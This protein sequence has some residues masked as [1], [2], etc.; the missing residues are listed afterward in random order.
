MQLFIIFFTKIFLRLVCRADWWLHMVKFKFEFATQIT[1]LR[2]LNLFLRVWTCLW[3]FKTNVNLRCWFVW[4]NL[5]LANILDTQ[6]WCQGLLIVWGPA[7][8]LGLA[9]C[10]VVV[11]DAIRDYLMDWVKS[12]VRRTSDFS[13]I[14]SGDESFLWFCIL[15]WFLDCN[16]IRILAANRRV[17]EML[18]LDWL[19]AR[20]WNLLFYC[21]IRL[22][23]CG[24][25]LVALLLHTV[26]WIA[27][28]FTLLFIRL[29]IRMQTLLVL[30][31]DLLHQ[32]RCSEV[33]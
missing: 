28:Y 6:F 4:G 32:N 22:T 18:L 30:Q 11:E 1:V 27:I 14:Q 29:D 19:L 21:Y 5:Y 16:I 8:S 23:A 9:T 13:D 7:F 25:Y 10:K 12:L 24:L 31:S 2:V 17:Y 3:V 26:A 15:N 33:W 20:S